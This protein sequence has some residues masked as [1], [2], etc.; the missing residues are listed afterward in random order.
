M[1]FSDL[2]KVMIIQRQTT[3]KWYNV[4][5]YLQWPTN[6]KSYFLWSIER[7]YFQWPWTT[8]TH[9]LKVTPFFDAEYVRNSMTSDI[10]SLK[11]YSGLTHAW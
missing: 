4:Q 2:F 11:Y 8:P 7:R 9:S 1:T 6:R 5:L 3:W 10:V